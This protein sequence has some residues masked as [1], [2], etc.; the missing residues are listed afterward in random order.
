MVECCCVCCICIK[1]AAFLLGRPTRR[2]WVLM[3]LVTVLAQ[4]VGQSVDRRLCP[5]SDALLNERN[6]PISE[7]YFF[8]I[9]LRSYY[10]NY[11]TKAMSLEDPRVRLRQLQQSHQLNEQTNIDGIPMQVNIVWNGLL[12]SLHIRLVFKSLKR[13][14]NVFPSFSERFAPAL[15]F[16]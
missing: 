8:L 14:R 2:V 1:F 5:E 3:A 6:I 4:K 12:M 9:F 7:L 15:P 13:T 16:N 11:L 10:F